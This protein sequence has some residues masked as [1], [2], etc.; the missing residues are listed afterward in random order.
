MQRKKCWD[1]DQERGFDCQEGSVRKERSGCYKE[2][3]YKGVQFFGELG[4]P[5]EWM[6]DEMRRE[7]E[8]MCQIDC[9]SVLGMDSR[10]GRPRGVERG[11]GIVLG[12]SA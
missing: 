1:N 11:V 2:E 4:C 6:V 12:N 10:C 7:E 8:K 9:L 3:E 5:V